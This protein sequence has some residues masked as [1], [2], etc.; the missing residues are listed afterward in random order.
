VT[1]AGSS[2]FQKQDNLAAAAVTRFHE[3]KAK[4]FA[5]APFRN[6]LIH[7]RRVLVGLIWPRSLRAATKG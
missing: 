6:R 4:Q 7:W 2:L 1:R 5:E 3:L